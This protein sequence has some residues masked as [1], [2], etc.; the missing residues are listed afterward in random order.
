MLK[1]TMQKITAGAVAALVALSLTSCGSFFGSGGSGTE[2]S[3]V[4][5]KGPIDAGMITVY[6]LN[7][8][9]TRGSI[10]AT[11]TTGADGAF[12]VD[13]GSYTGAVSV[14][15]TGG[16]Y[17]DEATGDTVVLGTGDELEA[18]LAEAAEGTSVGVTALTTIAAVRAGQDAA[19]G[20]ET[21]IAAANKDVADAFGLTGVDIASVI[22]S[23]LTQ[24]STSDEGSAQQYGAVQSGLC[25]IVENEGMSSDE[26][27]SLIRTMAED[28][29]D[30]EFD[31]TDAAGNALNNAL[32]IAPDHAVA[33]LETAIDAF[34]NSPENR[35][36]LGSGDVP[37]A[38][39]APGDTGNPAG[40]TN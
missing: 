23:N 34:L 6:A 22:P 35:S 16:S 2:I 15:V 38:V 39:P 17:V 8:D 12:S 14:A 11:G 3:G 5:T 7:S 36:G 4:A 32:S 18:L 31:G 30:G 1:T 9:G 20:L 19:N 25:Q 10:L 28:F 21:A 33:G 40:P 13:I 37:V 26:V 24:D 29:S 27:L